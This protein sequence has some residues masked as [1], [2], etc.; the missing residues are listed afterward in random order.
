MLLGEVGAVRQLDH[1]VAGLDPRQLR[2]DQFHRGLAAEA[3]AHARLEVRV[4]RM[5]PHR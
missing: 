5:E 1:Y 3:R 4:G 2:P